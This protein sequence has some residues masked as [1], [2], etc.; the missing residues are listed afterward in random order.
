MAILPVNDIMS[1]LVNDI[2]S[3]LVKI[4]KEAAERIQKVLKYDKHIMQQY[5]LQVTSI[6]KYTL[7]L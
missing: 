7:H 3:L 1:L 5:K 4:C 6:Y 2:M